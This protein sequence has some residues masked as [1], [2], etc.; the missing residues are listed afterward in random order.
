MFDVSANQRKQLMRTNGEFINQLR[1]EISEGQKRRTAF[2]KA[3]LAFV[4]GLLG[5][6]AFSVKGSGATVPL[7]YLVP[8]V[9]FIF[10]L[11]ALG[12]DFGI[13]RA[14]SFIQNS[15]AAPLEER[16]WEASLGKARDVL[17]FLANPLSTF[18][19]G[20]AAGVALL[21][22]GH[23]NM[24]SSRLLSVLWL[25]GAALTVVFPFAYGRIKS[26]RLAKYNEY[27]A[28]QPRGRDPER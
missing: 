9:A 10:D 7:L 11:Y 4:V 2:I 6:G 28:T 20:A 26:R 8:V 16:T 12:E 19:S 25:C 3:K 13:K 17:A 1:V 18:A 22:G 27:L 21:A 23:L 15:P 24:N 5:A 14:G